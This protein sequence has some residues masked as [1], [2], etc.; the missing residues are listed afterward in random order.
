MAYFLIGPPMPRPWGP[1]PMMY[2][3]CP[4]WVRWYSPWTPPPMHFHPGWSGPAEGFSHGG[5]YTEDGRYGSVSHQQDR[6]S[7]RQDNQT[8]QNAKLNH[9]VSPKATKPLVSSTSSGCP[10]PYLLLMDQGAI[11]IRQGQGVRL[12]PMMKRSIAWRKV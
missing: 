8:V 9:L 12:W 6:K 1:P 5:Y 11:K 10:K 2:L 4:P 7:P 3:P